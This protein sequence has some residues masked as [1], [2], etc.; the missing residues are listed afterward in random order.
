ML[1]Y[2]AAPWILWVSR[3]LFYIVIFRMLPGSRKKSESGTWRII[4]NG[5]TVNANSH[6]HNPF[7]LSPFSGYPINIT[8]L[9]L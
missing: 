4:Q 1:P 5:P 2:I 6:Y 9:Y 8:G 3:D 7:F